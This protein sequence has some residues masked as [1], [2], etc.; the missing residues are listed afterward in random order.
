MLINTLSSVA[1]SQRSDI[2]KTDA[3]LLAA[4]DS[5]VSGRRTQDVADIAVASQ[6]QS[7]VVGLKQVS[8]NLAQASSI[9]QVADGGLEQSQAVVDR[10]RNIA[11][12]AQNG[13][14][15]DEQRAQ[16]NEEFQA[17]AKQLDHIASETRFN[18]TSLLDGSLED[19]RAISLNRLLATDSEGDNRLSLGSQSRASLFAGQSLDVL[20]VD[21]AAK[22]LD[23]LS[24]AGEQLTS[25]RAQVGSFAKTLDYAAASVDSAVANQEAARSLLSDADFLD[26]ATQSQQAQVQRNA[27]LSLAAQTNKLPS[28]LLQLVS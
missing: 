22:A 16:L 13:A 21:G 1:A 7:Q 10:L 3:K 9:V 24:T 17:L 5:L 12:Q 18:G 19:D 14:T 8:Q 6:L 25:A 11:Q 26:A 28:A 15:N 4:I 27:Q 23:V 2:K 20:S